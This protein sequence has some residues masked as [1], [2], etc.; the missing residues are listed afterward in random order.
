MDIE[1]NVA[2]IV[3][4]ATVAPIIGAATAGATVYRS[5]TKPRRSAKM[6][7]F[8]EISQ[9]KTATADS[10]GAA[11]GIITFVNILM[12]EHP[13]ILACLSSSIGREEKKPERTQ[14]ASGMVR[15]MWAKTSPGTVPRRPMSL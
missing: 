3:G 11:I 6:N 2:K 15:V 9:T 7:S 4:S 13:S 8:H 1:V 12:R 14:V 10:P 5:F